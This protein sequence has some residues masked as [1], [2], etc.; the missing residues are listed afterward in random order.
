[1]AVDVIMPPMGEVFSKGTITNGSRNRATDRARMSRCRNLT[2]KV[3]AEIRPLGTGVKESRL[4]RADRADPDR[5]R[6]D[7]RG[8]DSAGAPAAA[9]ARARGHPAPAATKTETQGSGQVNRMPPT[10]SQPPP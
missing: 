7:R 9:P 8:W 1:M 6:R 4:R 5:G 10:T 2:D 3:D